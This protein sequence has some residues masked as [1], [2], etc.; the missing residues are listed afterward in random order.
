MIQVVTKAPGQAP[1]V[2]LIDGSVESIQ[3]EV[4]GYFEVHRFWTRALTLYCNEDGKNKYMAPNVRDLCH[5][6]VL[7]GTVLVMRG[8]NGLTDDDLPRVIDVLGART[9]LAEA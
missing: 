3:K 2:R 7:V 8:D 1:V 9:V 5:P 4:G 6:E